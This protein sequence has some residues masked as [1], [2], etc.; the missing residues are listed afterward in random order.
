M[1]LQ[2]N[3]IPLKLSILVC[4]RNKGTNIKI[5][6]KIIHAM[7]EVPHEILFVHDDPDIDFVELVNS[8]KSRDP[9]TRL[10][11][12][13]S[14]NGVVN[15]LKSG[16]DASRGE[17]VLI[18]AADEVGPV[19]AIEDMLKLMGQG[20]DLVSC[21]RYA[22]GGRRLGGS[23]IGHL[24]SWSANKLFFYLFRSALSDCTTGIKM[25]RKSL[26]DEIE[27][28]SNSVG[29]SIAFEISIKVQLLGLKLGEVPIVSVDR[30][31]GGTPAF[32]LGPWFVE[33]LRWFV[34]GLKNFKQSRTH[35]SKPALVRLPYYYR[36][37]EP[38]KKTV[39]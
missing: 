11:R 5:M 21:T 7:I 27:L 24:L 17:Y 37:S 23:K 13:H 28:E 6:L 12:N 1:S 20:C 26:F 39:L 19:L 10:I 34:W 36:I 32:Q 25:F 31:F 35:K 30:L 22:H 4:V 38:E 3:S 15:A 14:G 2:K 9:N 33:Y 8:L 29:W 16:I 18:F